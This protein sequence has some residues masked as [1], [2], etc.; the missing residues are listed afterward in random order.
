MTGTLLL[1]HREDAGEA[2]RV[3]ETYSP[4]RDA[5]SR[6]EC[7]VEGSQTRELE[8]AARI[9]GFRRPCIF[10]ARRRST[11]GHCLKAV[12]LALEEA[13]VQCHWRIVRSRGCDFPPRASLSIAAAW[14]HTEDLSQLRG[15]R[16]EIV[17]LMRR[18]SNCITCCG[19]CT[20]ATPSTWFLAPEGK[21]VVGATS[22][23]T[24]DRSPMFRA[25]S[26]GATDLCIFDDSRPWQKRASSNS[27]RRCGL[28][29]Q[30][31]CQRF[32]SI[33]ERKVLH[34]NGLYR[35]G[36]LADARRSSRKYWVCC[37]GDRADAG[38]VW[39]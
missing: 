16:G 4:S 15:V 29:C 35:H 21:L 6:I 32:S 23:E 14:V 30:T 7:H 33:V 10:P 24:D 34:I 25:W 26:S 19:C 38:P 39:M 12:A 13:G 1:W 17:R 8:P 20:R 36:F 5:Q 3:R 37:P 18:R 9:H 27:T 11:I 31:I 2:A 28:P 22:I